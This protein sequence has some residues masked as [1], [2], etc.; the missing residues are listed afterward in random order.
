MIK[1]FSEELF[2]TGRRRNMGNDEIVTNCLLS[3]IVPVYNTEKYIENCL[4]SLLEQDIDKSVYEIICVHD[5]STDGSLQILKEYAEKYDNIVL[6][7]KSNEGVSIAR[8]LGLEK[9]QGKYIWFIDSDDWIARDCLGVIAQEIQKYDPS[10][11]QIDFDYIQAEWRVKECA[12]VFLHKENVKCSV[13]NVSVLPYVGACSSIIKKELLN[14]YEHKFIEHL[15]YGE[16]VLFMRELF[17]RMRM[18][19]EQ[20]DI[21]HKMVHCQDEIFYYYRMHDESAMR[22]SWSKHRERYMESLLK[23]ACI[24]QARMQ[25]TSKPKWYNEEYEELFYQR[26]YNYMMD[27]LPG[28][29]GNLKEQLRQLRKANLYPCP[30]PSKKVQRKLTEVSGI[31]RIKVLY[32]YFAFRWRW[33]Y[34]LYYMQMKRKYLKAER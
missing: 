29:Y 22:S 19:G 34:P 33:L 24:D 10:V 30:K 18:E 11:V 16:D 27:W 5:G 23:M 3:I 32:R 1:L 8:N 25:D 26:I 21:V 20:G 28:G 17:D 9:A 31:S 4:D 2:Y 12:N 7:D 14:H 6:I 13:H 15:H